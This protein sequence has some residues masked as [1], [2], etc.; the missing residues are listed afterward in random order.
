VFLTPDQG[1]SPAVPPA[2]DPCS[3][4]SGATKVACPTCAGQGRSAS[5]ADQGKPPP[6][7]R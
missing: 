7:R 6:D 3:L 4:C 2:S 5:A 1:P